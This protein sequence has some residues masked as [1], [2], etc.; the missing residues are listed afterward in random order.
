M[1]HVRN[2]FSALGE[3]LVDKNN[4]S[5]KLELVFHSVAAVKRQSVHPSMVQITSYFCHLR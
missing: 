4:T 5:V 1:A 2:V 3:I